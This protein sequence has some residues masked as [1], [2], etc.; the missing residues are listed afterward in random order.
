MRPFDHTIGFAHA[1]SK[2]LVGTIGPPTDQTCFD[3]HAHCVPVFPA[4]VAV[5]RVSRPDRAALHIPSLDGLRA[6]SF[7][8]VFAAHC[9]APYVPGGFGVTV[10]FFLSGFLITTLMRLELESTGTVNFR[11]FYL[12]RVLRILPPFY[13][14]LALAVTLTLLDLLPG[15]LQV[16]PVVSQALHFFN[17]WI[18]RNGT[19][20]TPVGTVPYWSLAVEEHFYLLFPML[21]VAVSRRLARPAQARVFWALCA[22]ICLWRVFLVFV[23]RVPDDRTYMGSDTRFDSIFFGCALAIGANPILDRPRIG[24][25]W[26]KW[27]IV[28]A[29]IVIIGFTFAYR[30]SWFRETIRYSLQGIALTPI[31]ITAVRYPGW[32]P[33]R[34]LN[35]R[36]VAF[37]GVLSYVLYLVHQV[38]LFALGYRLHH[39]GMLP[40]ALAALAI[41]F[42]IAVIVHYYVEKPAQELRKRLTRR[43]RVA[44]SSAPS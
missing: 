31:F 12:R 33:Y 4:P 8:I 6:V 9:G 2:Q 11:H 22:A 39:L 37:F 25:A 16:M 21:Y 10:F 41:S 28:P 29:C 24:E 38:V 20:G 26:W 40:R 30:M 34:L 1:D 5:D 35:T 14:I 19:D 36:P 32:L 43:S 27:V 13:L 7:L 23:M 44:P 15:R 3:A 17:Y 18:I 42:L